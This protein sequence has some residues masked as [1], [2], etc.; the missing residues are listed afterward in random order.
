MLDYQ[1]LGEISGKRHI[2]ES[3]S[4]AWDGHQQCLA[5]ATMTSLLSGIGSHLV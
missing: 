2:K 3:L 1:Q 4:S 5:N